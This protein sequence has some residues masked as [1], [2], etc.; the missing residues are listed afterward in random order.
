LGLVVGCWLPL[1]GNWKRFERG[2]KRLMLVNIIFCR[3]RY[4]AAQNDIMKSTSAIK[5]AFSA[6]AINSS[7]SVLITHG[8]IETQL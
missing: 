7:S 3:K 2:L 4:I 8:F 6:G 1:F 5:N